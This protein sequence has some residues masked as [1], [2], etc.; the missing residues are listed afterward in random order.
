MDNASHHNVP[1]YFRLVTAARVYAT[2]RCANVRALVECKLEGR[3]YCPI[4]F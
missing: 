2:C 1:V 4:Y 3:K